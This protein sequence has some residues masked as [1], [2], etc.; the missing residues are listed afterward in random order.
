[1]SNATLPIDV[2]ATRRALIVKLND[3]IADLE[4]ARARRVIANRHVDNDD[5]RA[6]ELGTAL[7]MKQER[8]LELL[9]VAT[10]EAAFER[11]AIALEIDDLE[12]AIANEASDRHKHRAEQ[13]TATACEVSAQ[14]VV[15]DLTTRLRKLLE[16]AF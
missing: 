15:D 1:M 14:K 8:L 13:G 6:L 9:I 10:D 2:P 7:T 16:P 5:G 12:V 3:A 4:V 11:L